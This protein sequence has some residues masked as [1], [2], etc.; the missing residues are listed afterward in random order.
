MRDY[1]HGCSRKK[2][3][4]DRD[5]AYD[6]EEKYIDGSDRERFLRKLYEVGDVAGYMAKNYDIKKAENREVYT[7]CCVQ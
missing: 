1:T 2:Q 6:D 7:M 5:S 4:I 3:K